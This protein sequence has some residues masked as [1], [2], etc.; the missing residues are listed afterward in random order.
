VSDYVSDLSTCITASQHARHAA[1][2]DPVLRD[3][4]A[5]RRPRSPTGYQL[6]HACPAQPIPYRRHIAAT[7]PGRHYSGS[8]AWSFA[9]I[10]RRTS[11]MGS[12]R[13]ARFDYRLRTFT[14]VGIVRPPP[15]PSNRAATILDGP[16]TDRAVRSPARSMEALTSCGSAPSL[17]PGTRCPSAVPEAFRAQPPCT[18]GRRGS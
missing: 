15:T 4:H 7:P 14:K 10:P 2:T 18:I 13:S 11:I 9:S 16:S 17:M 3:Q 8:S 5:Q 1:Q 6:L 12:T